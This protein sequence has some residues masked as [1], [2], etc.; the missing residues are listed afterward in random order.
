[1]IDQKDE[2]ITL[3]IANFNI[4]GNFVMPDKYMIKIHYL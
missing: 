2:F 1:M 4:L 3:Y